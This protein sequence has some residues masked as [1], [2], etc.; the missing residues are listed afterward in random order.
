MKFSG[1]FV[2]PDFLFANNI[3]RFSNILYYDDED[4][5]ITLYLITRIPNLY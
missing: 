5:F 3:L 4:I 2:V 1:T